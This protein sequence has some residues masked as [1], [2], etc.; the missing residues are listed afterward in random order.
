MALFS[1]KQPKDAPRRRQAQGSN[2]RITESQLD[3]R[4]SFRRNRTLTGSSSS[5]VS[6]PNEEAAQLKSSRVHAHELATKR[7]HIS[8]ILLIVLL[9][10]LGLYI[11]I[12]QF[13]AGTVI[14]AADT[15]LKLDPNYAN[16]LQS[17]FSSQPIERLRFIMNEE[18]LTGYMQSRAPE[19]ASVRLDGDA[20]FGKSRFIVEVRRPIAGW[21]VNGHQQYVDG[22][23]T[24]FSRNYFASPAVEIIDKSGVQVEAGQAVASNRF[25]AFVGRI[26]GLTPTWGY[27][28]TQIVIPSGTTREVEASFEGIKYP[29]KLSVD[30]PEGEQ[31]EDAARAIAWMTAHK[32]SP[33]YID[34]RVGG[35]AYYR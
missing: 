30:R 14:R 18:H 5:K 20:G 23:G 9:V 21:T 4:Y 11:L 16:I 33:Q 17:Y 1:R 15:S 3:E 6:T 19:I 8:A 34:V 31:I 7:R 32:L 29:V 2:E 25:L 13:T 12:S 27:K 26:V 22:T 10:S 28:V 24:P 35:K